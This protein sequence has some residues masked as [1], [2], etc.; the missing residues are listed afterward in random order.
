MKMAVVSVFGKRFSSVTMAEAQSTEPFEV[1]HEQNG[2]C[3]C[4][5]EPYDPDSYHL[6]GCPSLFATIRVGDRKQVVSRADIR[7]ISCR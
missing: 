5:Y 3:N 6:P 4:H 1:V 7:I 2:D